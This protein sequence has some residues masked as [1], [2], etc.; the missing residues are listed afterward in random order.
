MIRKLYCSGVSKRRIAMVLNISRTTVDR[1][2]SFLAQQAIK[3]QEVLK[4]EWENDKLKRVEIDEMETHINTKHKPLSLALAVCSDKESKYYRKILGFKASKM[5]ARHCHEKIAN[6][7]Y[8]VRPDERQK[9][10]NEFMKEIAPYIDDRAIIRSDKCPRYPSAVRKA[11]PRVKHETYWGRRSIIIG[12]G[13]LKKAGYD[14]IFALN[15]TAA[16]IRANV[17]RLI[18][19]TWCTSKKTKNLMEHLYLYMDYHNTVLT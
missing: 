3:N 17:N 4:K 7:K 8:G 5:P 1:K 10:I 13:E 18:R 9:G 12:Q 11:L 16:M 15:H 19:K 14:P 6:F 2:I